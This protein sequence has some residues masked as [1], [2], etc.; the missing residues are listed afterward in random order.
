MSFF[1]YPIFMSRRKRKDALDNLLLIVKERGIGKCSRC[2]YKFTKEE[3]GSQYDTRKK[4]TLNK[5][6]LIYPDDYDSV[7]VLCKLEAEPDMRNILHDEEFE[8]IKKIKRWRKKN[9]SIKS[10]K[11]NNK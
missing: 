6:E 4:S 5:V 9:K 2:G 1:K 11:S 10:K 7:C 8:L 3:E